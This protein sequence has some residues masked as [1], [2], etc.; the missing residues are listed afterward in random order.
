MFRVWD[1]SLMLC[2]SLSLMFFGVE[3]E[4]ELPPPRNLTFKWETPFTLRLT[5]KKPKDLEPD[6]SVN[7]TVNAIPSQDCS[8]KAI[9]ISYT[10]RVKNTTCKLNIP[11]VN[12]LCI[13][14]KVNPEECG[15]KKQ[16]PPLEISIPPPPVR[17]V[18]NMSFEYYHDRLKCTWDSDVD[19]PDLGLYYWLPQKEMVKK[20]NE[21]KIGECVINDTFHN[22]E[23]FYLFN[24]TYK[25]QPVNNTFRQNSSTY[26]VKLE[27]PK[28]TIQRI[29][30][31]LRFHTNFTVSEF[32][33]HCY[34][35]NYIYSK[36]DEIK[37]VK[38]LDSVYK[39]DYDSSC[40]Y[41]AR[42]QI[43]L[44]S[45]CGAGKSDLSDEVEYGENRD[46]NLPALLAGIIIP[47]ML[48]CFLIVSLVLLRRHKDIIFP[49]IPEPTL[50]F[51]DMF[52]NNIRTAE[53]LRSTADGRLYIPI[54]EIV[55]NKIRLEPETPLIPT[56]TDMTYKQL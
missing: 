41:R 52:I 15:N 34:E 31:S 29:E 25:G 47:L 35:K 36:C 55:E 5:W 24:G 21:M 46:S 8:E 7:Y 19:V 39:V 20:C 32:G 38:V 3:G 43:I 44:S 33:A 12:G 40:K 6:C 28:L 1:I 56:K 16:S 42:V 14:V 53:D 27:K 49:K 51:K 18:K 37:Q 45:R 10:T 48:S 22:K 11:N 26:F 30:Q 54:E 23:M 9:T 17:L 13:S 50:I 4:S 2:F